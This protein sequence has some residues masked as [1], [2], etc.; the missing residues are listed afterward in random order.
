MTAY[1]AVLLYAAWMIVLALA[2][3]S[4]R[5]PLA[6]FGKK[7]IDSWERG[8]EPIDPLFLQRAKSAHMNAIENFPLFAAVVVIAGLMD[9][10]AMANSVAAYV[11]YARVA[12]SVVHISGTSFVQ[13]MLRATFYLVQLALIVYM[14]LQLVG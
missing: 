13:V 2:Y 5:I 7:P 8:K 1:T 9:Q 4:P 12:Q 6:L 3:A 11:L 14:I 10:I